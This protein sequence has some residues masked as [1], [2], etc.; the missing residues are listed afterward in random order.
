M[1]S[2]ESLK[3]ARLRFEPGIFLSA[4]RRANNLTKATKVRKCLNLLL[5]VGAGSH[6][7]C[8]DT[9]IWT[10]IGPMIACYKA[11]SVCLT[12]RADRLA[13]QG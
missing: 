5:I 10:M 13:G 8:M 11:L 9:K 3:G 4:S 1:P 6:A 2:E 12:D 7:E